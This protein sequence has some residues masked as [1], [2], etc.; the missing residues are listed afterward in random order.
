[1]SHPVRIFWIPYHMVLMWPKDH[2][3]ILPEPLPSAI[4]VLAPQ[5]LVFDF[6]PTY[7][8]QPHPSRSAGSIGS[9]PS[10]REVNMPVHWVPLQT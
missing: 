3:V 5:T 9:H 2:I 1:M 4:G 7:G 10:R 8:Q 6:L